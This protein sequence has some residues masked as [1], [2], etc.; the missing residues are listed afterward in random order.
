MA[1]DEDS[2]I[3]D[4]SPPDNDHNV[5]TPVPIE[6]E[7]QAISHDR[8]QPSEQLGRGKR[9]F[10]VMNQSVD[11]SLSPKVYHLEQN[12][13]AKRTHTEDVNG[14]LH[15]IS[16][17]EQRIS[18]NALNGKQDNA[19]DGKGPMPVQVQLPGPAKAELVSHGKSVI[20]SAQE[21]S[22]SDS[23]IPAIDATLATDDE[24]EEE[25]EKEDE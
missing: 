5:E 6:M 16:T 1:V 22:D 24:E 23:D 14:M 25:E 21:N 12:E 8:G 18:A 13:T 19:A 10:A 9:D 20:A 2:L 7:A 4:L 11:S 3:E 17:E 15:T